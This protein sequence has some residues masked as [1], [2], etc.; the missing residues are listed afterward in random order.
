[1]NLWFLADL[2]GPKGK[3]NLHY[4]T[5]KPK[6]KYRQFPA[7]LQSRQVEDNFSPTRYCIN[8]I[9][10]TDHAPQPLYYTFF[11]AREWL[12]LQYYL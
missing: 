7:R 3:Y 10:I 11:R 6:P 2:K 1:M 4:G 8:L 5:K 9:N 12:H